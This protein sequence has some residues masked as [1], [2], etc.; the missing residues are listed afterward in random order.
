MR[1]IRTFAVALLTL[2]ALAVVAVMS[3]ALSEPLRLAAA[4]SA[5]KAPQ[6][7]SAQDDDDSP[8]AKMSARF[9]QKIRTGDLL[10]LPVLDDG[11]VTLGHVRKVIRTPEGKTKLIVSYSR[12]FGLGGRLVAV[13][14]E[15]VAI[16]GRQLASLDME[17]ADYEAA[18]TW[19]EAGNLEIPPDEIIRIAITR[20]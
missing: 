1:P 9:P 7:D 13:P 15:V 6:V 14:I 19:V 5:A 12:W 18:P 10:G 17:P 4:P 20:R 2:P 3:A 11:D 8:E 16:L